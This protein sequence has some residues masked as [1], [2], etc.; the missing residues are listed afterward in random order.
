[1]RPH[2]AS[3]VADWRRNGGDRAIIR[4]RGNRAYSTR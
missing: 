2:L 1:M 4:H 3:L